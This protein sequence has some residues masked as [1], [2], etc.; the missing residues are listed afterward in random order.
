MSNLPVPMPLTQADYDM[1]ES[2]V[3]ETMRGRWFLAEYARRN[4]HA[5]TTMLLSAIDR[6]EAAVRDEPTTRLVERLRSDLLEMANSIARTKAEIAS[7]QPDAV[8]QGKFGEATEEL[9]SIVQATE[10][11]TSQILAAAEQVQEIAWTLRE[12]GLDPAV[13][14]RLDAKA[15]EIY[16]ACSFQDLT[17]QRTSKVIEVMRYL[18]GRIDAMIDI[19]GLSGAISAA[20]APKRVAARLKAPAH[21]PPG[22]N[23]GDVDLVMGRAGKEHAQVDDPPAS[24]FDAVVAPTPVELSPAAPAPAYADLP[25]ASGEARLLRDEANDAPQGAPRTPASVSFAMPARDAAATEALARIDALS[26]E[27]KIALFG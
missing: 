17:G 9:D 25:A 4:R 2:A 26:A 11:A 13:C 24:P 8:Q 22:L 18:E 27:E 12:H 3:L 15:T 21:P 10:I 23:Q 6:L 14:D 16:T 19:W 20:A 5:D 7:M 1:I